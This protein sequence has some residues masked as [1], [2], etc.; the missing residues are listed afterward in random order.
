MMAFPLLVPFKLRI[1]NAD[2]TGPSP[3]S[4]WVNSDGS[5]AGKPQISGVLLGSAS[6]YITLQLGA[7]ME[8]FAIGC[9]TGPNCI[10]IGSTSFIASL[11]G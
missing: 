4:A 11:L 1:A 7:H 3:L 8:A 2:H 10:K 6:T 9:F 5:V